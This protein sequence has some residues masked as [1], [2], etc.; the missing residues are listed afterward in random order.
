MR[1]VFAFFYRIRA[2]ILLVLLLLFC[3]NLLYRSSPMQRAAIA[4]STT[5]ISGTIYGWRHEI[6]AYLHLK[7]ENEKLNREI[8]RLRARQKTSFKVVPAEQFEYQDDLYQQIYLF[9]PAQVINSTINKP[10][11]TLTLN[12]GS[13]HGVKVGNGVISVDGL[14]GVVTEVSSNYCIAMPIINKQFTASVEIKGKQFFG[15][16]G[17]SGENPRYA[18][19]YDMADFANVNVGDTIVSRGASAIFPR[20]VIVGTIA[21][22]ERKP[23]LGK[24]DVSVKLAVN[25]AKL[26]NVAIVNHVYKEELMLLESDD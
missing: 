5:N 16:L 9:R 12:L 20:G 15:L 25:F 10:R 23:S 17:W 14:V 2:E 11:N 24:L 13:N 7:E 26:R 22:L 1:N 8:Q 6:S 18:S 21:Q 3:I 4:K 19:I